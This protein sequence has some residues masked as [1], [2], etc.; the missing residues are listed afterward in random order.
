MIYRNATKIVTPE[1]PLKNP[2]KVRISENSN[3]WLI[4]AVLPIV[5]YREETL[6]SNALSAGMTPELIEITL[7]LESGREID[8]TE[9]DHH[10][11]E[12]YHPEVIHNGYVTRIKL[13]PCGAGIGSKEVLKTPM[14]LSDIAHWFDLSSMPKPG[15]FGSINMDKPVNRHGVTFF[16]SY[17]IGEIKEIER[18]IFEDVAYCDINKDTSNFD[19]KTLAKFPGMKLLDNHPALKTV[20]MKNRK[21][22]WFSKATNKPSFWVQHE[23]FRATGHIFR[24]NTQLSKCGGTDHL[25]ALMTK[26]LA[27]GMPDIKL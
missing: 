16:K 20:F 26:E 9:N 10:L 22:S 25:C 12:Q 6:S 24:D 5:R 1:G 4:N 2:D 18:P 15:V 27:I 11:W 8:I 14:L 3:V 23:D 19:G 17:D 21:T 13:T 7:K